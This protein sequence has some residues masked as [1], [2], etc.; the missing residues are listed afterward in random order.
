M[1][2]KKLYVAW[3]SLYRDTD[4]KNQIKKKKD[5]WQKTM[6]NI[7]GKGLQKDN[8]WKISVPGHIC[9][10]N[11]QETALHSLEGLLESN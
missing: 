10:I 8:F 5:F 3:K 11:I 9:A 6:D 1:I 4:A 2:Y 7:Q